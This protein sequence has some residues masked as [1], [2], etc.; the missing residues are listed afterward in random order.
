MAELPGADLVLKEHVKLTIGKTL[1]LRE[2][3][4]NPDDAESTEAGPEESRLSSP[5]PCVGVQ[6]ARLNDVDEDTCQI[7][8]I[9]CQYDSLDA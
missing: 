2:T 1:W 9:A 6:H 7:V 4:V 5:G 8:E 3:E